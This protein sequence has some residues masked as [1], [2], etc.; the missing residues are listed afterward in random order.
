[1]IFNPF[2]TLNV[3]ELL[4]DLNY[5]IKI[6][7][8]TFELLYTTSLDQKNSIQ[9]YKKYHKAA[10]ELSLNFYSEGCASYE[11]FSTDY[12]H[13]LA[14]AI[15]NSM[16]PFFGSVIKTWSTFATKTNGKLVN[17]TCTDIVES[18]LCHAQSS[19]QYKNAIV[20]HQPVTQRCCIAML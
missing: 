19:I 4:I 13:K 15:G 5:N 11:G 12:H 2:G 9:L 1:M 18:L 16:N 17:R 6:I 3:F 8:S 20:Y 10:Q 14:I 7:K